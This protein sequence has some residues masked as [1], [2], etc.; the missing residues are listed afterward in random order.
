MA[1]RVP[2]ASAVLQTEPCHAVTLHSASSTVAC[3]SFRDTSRGCAG[4]PPAE[5]PWSDTMEFRKIKTLLGGVRLKKQQIF[6]AG[7]NSGSSSG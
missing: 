6:V 7:N 4:C 5:S 1:E 3:S 2:E